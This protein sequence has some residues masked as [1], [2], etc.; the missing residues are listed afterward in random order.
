[1]RTTLSLDPDV[2]LR[3]QERLRESQGTTMKE[4]VND[5]LRIGLKQAKPKAAV[6]YRVKTVSLGLKPGLD[7]DK[8]NALLDEL[9][10]EATLEKFRAD[11]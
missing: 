10:V 4:V 3:I 2:A 7:P 6:P 8:L 5:A 11:S 9:E 1:M